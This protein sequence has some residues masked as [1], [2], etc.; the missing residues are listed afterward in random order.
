MLSADEKMGNLSNK[1]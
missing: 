1:A